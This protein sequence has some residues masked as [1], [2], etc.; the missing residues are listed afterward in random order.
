MLCTELSFNIG[1]EYE[2]LFQIFYRDVVFE[3]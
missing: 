1:K 3:S 2:T